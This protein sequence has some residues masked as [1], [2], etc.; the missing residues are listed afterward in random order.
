MAKRGVN[1]FKLNRRGN[2]ARMHLGQAIWPW[3]DDIGKEDNRTLAVGGHASATV[4]ACAVQ[5]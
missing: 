3:L 4:S 1:N 2:V 5:T